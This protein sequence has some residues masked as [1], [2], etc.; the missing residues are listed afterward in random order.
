SSVARAGPENFLLRGVRKTFGPSS[1]TLVVSSL[2]DFC[3][4][5]QNVS[6]LM[7]GLFL[8]TAF[9]LLM[10]YGPF[11]SLV[12]DSLFLPTLTTLMIGAMLA[13]FGGITFGGVGFL[14]SSDQLWM[15]KGAPR[16]ELKFIRA[17]LTSY[18]LLVLPY[19]FIPSTLATLLMGYGVVEFLVMTG[20]F[21][22]A[23]CGT[24]MV[25]IGVTAFN[26]SYD[27]TSSSAFTINTVATMF[28]T[29]IVMACSFLPGI[30][31]V[32]N[33]RSYLLGIFTASIPWIIAGLAVLAVGVLRL[34]RSETA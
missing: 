27:D 13:I 3:R 31:I 20:F 9:I 25:G 14:D 21:F 26:P 28:T 29:I 32:I 1:G 33:E 24:I 17:R 18:M 22:I 4:K 12:N 15:L 7:Y 5:L 19:V 10:K 8:S 6:K 30:M 16:G 2:K 11:G 23:M 34:I